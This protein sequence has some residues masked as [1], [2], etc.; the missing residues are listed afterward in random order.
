VVHQTIPT[1][2]VHIPG[3]GKNLGSRHKD[4]DYNH[5]PG[6]VNFWLPLTQ[7]FGTNSLWSESAPGKG[8]YHAFEAELGQVVRF[9]GNQCEHYTV[10]NVENITRVSLDFRVIPCECYIP[11]YLP[12]A[13]LAKNPNRTVVSYE[14]GGWY[15]WC[16][17]PG[18]EADFYD[19]MEE[20]SNKQNELGQ[21]QPET[22][23]LIS[24]SPTKVDSSMALED[25]APRLDLIGLADDD[26]Y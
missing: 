3:T 7:V 15:Q 24:L 1:F 25:F 22:G 20:G 17:Q 21:E 13:L 12:T 9:W 5:Q 14:I 4:A 18:E 16:V 8:D 26:D 19:W 10:E 6:E 11:H 23:S 2:R